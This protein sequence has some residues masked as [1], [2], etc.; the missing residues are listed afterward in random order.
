ME[1]PRDAFV[2]ARSLDEQKEI[3]AVSVWRKEISGLLVAPA[4]DILERGKSRLN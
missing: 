1:E 4:A 2:R 3:A